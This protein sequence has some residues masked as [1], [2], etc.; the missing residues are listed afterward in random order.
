MPLHS[1]AHKMGWIPDVADVVNDYRYSGP[2]HDTA[3]LPKEL[4]LRD[5]HMPPIW[6]QGALGSCTAF[7]SLRAY[8]YAAS[9][10]GLPKISTSKLAQYYWSRL[11][12][13]A[14]Y[15][16]QDSGSTTTYALKAMAKYGVALEENDPYIVSRFDKAPSRA[17]TN[18]AHNRLVVKYETVPHS[19]SAIK[20]ALASGRLVVFGMTCYTSLEYDE[21]GRTGIIPIP[22]RGERVIGGHE[23]AFAGWRSDG[24]MIVPNS[25][26]EMAG[27][28]GYYYMHP[29]MAFA[30]GIISNIKVID[31]I[32]A[33][34]P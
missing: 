17:A 27:D 31:L 18:D 33:P 20:S 19:E 26:G 8:E 3:V 16:H 14:Q 21:T 29:E 25:W 1:A 28:H 30:S 12:M 22:K 13:G 7:A 10:Q 4:D 15:V 24:L 6:D 5:E 34:I 32:E 9:V 2:I 23:V 11:L